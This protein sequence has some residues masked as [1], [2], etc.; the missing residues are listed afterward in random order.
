MGGRE[1]LELAA[2]AAGIEGCEWQKQGN[3]M[4][5]PNRQT[6]KLTDG[7][8]EEGFSFWNPLT[9]DGDA[10]R[11]AVKLAIDLYFHETD[12]EATAFQAISR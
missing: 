5:Y 6:V 2:K 7:S 3:G 11:L 8:T 12:V 1:I 9:D 4:I 10:L